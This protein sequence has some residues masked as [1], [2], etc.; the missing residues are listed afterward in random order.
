MK[1]KKAFSKRK[2]TFKFISKYTGKIVFIASFAT[3]VFVSYLIHYQ[4]FQFDMFNVISSSMSPA[5]ERGSLL[6]SEPKSAYLPSDVI[7]FFNPGNINSK[8]VHRIDSIEIIDGVKTYRTKGDANDSIDP[9]K[10]SDDLIIGKVFI[11]IP[12]VGFA[13]SIIQSPLGVLLLIILPLGGL[14]FLE[15]EDLLVNLRKV[16]EGKKKS[17][18]KSGIPYGV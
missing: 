17:N 12:Y 13:I 9:W 16:L 14:F 10:V 3:L 5:I 11:I 4:V 18:E 15:L 2:E 6:I 7:S 8:V 1:L